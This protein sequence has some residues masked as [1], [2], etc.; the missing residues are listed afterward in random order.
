LI[1]GHYKLA[2][3]CSEEKPGYLPHDSA[4]SLM[5]AAAKVGSPRFRHSTFSTPP[6]FL[7][8]EKLCGHIL[9]L[10]FSRPA[11]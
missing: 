2:L 8:V 9:A 5:G 10:V 7:G 1:V 6:G 4:K 11:A 3:R